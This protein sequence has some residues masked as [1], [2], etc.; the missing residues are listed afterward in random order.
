M[1]ELDNYR[2]RMIDSDDLDFLNSIRL[3]SH[4]QNNVG[5]HLFTNNFLQKNWIENI[6]KSSKDKYLILEIKKDDFVNSSKNS[7]QKIGLIRFNEIDFINRSMCVGG[8]IAH[9]F[10]GKGHGKKMYEIIFK[11]CFEIWG[12]NRLW[13]SVLEYNLRAINLYKKIGFT[14]EGVSREAIFKNGKFENYVMMSLLKS[15][16]KY[17]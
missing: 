9:D 15:D 1:I 14:Q 17:K 16:E 13:L 5:F 2:A 12:M 11:I 7:W 3:S 6:S 10:I 8:D 4:V